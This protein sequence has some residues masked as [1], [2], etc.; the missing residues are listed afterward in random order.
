MR[1]PRYGYIHVY[2][3]VE[4]GKKMETLMLFEVHVYHH[5]NSTENEIATWVILQFK[6]LKPSFRGMDMY[7]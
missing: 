7:A 4:D 1:F 6:E 2:V 3:Y 5:G